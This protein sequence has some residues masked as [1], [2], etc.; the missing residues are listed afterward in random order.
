MI[1]QRTPLSALSQQ[2]RG[3]I[4]SNQSSER[5]IHGLVRYS[6]NH[7]SRLGVTFLTPDEL[8]LV[9]GKIEGVSDEGFVLRDETETLEI[10]YNQIIKVY[11]A[12]N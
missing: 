1:V 5:N 2:R 8:I 11:A 7:G 12:P 3:E 6:L 4:V 10:R 9:V